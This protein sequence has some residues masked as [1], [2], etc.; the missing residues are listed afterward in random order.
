MKH[1]NNNIFSY[2]D[3]GFQQI[4]ELFEYHFNRMT[5]IKKHEKKRI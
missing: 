4:S 1:N 2:M 3:V 5:L